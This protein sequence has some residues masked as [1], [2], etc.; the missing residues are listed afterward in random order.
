MYEFN[1]PKPKLIKLPTMVE[2]KNDK[3]FYHSQGLCFNI[4]NVIDCDLEDKFQLFLEHS[5]LTVW[6]PIGKSGYRKQ[7]TIQSLKSKRNK[8]WLSVDPLVGGSSIIAPCLALTRK[9]E[10]NMNLYYST[11]DKYVG[12]QGALRHNLYEAFRVWAVQTY[13]DKYCF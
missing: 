5:G 2:L 6:Y 11:P 3:N 9:L 13:P 4:Q 1:L 7:K 10:S 12:M 8:L